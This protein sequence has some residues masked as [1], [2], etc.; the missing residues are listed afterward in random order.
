[1]TISQQVREFHKTYSQ[2]IRTVPTLNVPERKLRFDLII[3]EVGELQDALEADDLVEVADALGD[4]AYVVYGAALTFGIPLDEIIDEIHRSNMS[5]LGADGRP[6][7]RE[8][9][10]KV[11]KGPDYFTPTPGIERILAEATDS[12]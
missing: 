2:P 10:R 4:I 5:K 6:I 9:D 11:L 3:E 8:S 1:M 12:V 7:Y